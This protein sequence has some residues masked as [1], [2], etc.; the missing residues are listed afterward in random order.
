V[1]T[2]VRILRTATGLL[3]LGLLIYFGRVDL[4]V[5]RE[6]L[7]HPAL[8]VLAG[9]L[10]VSAVPIAALRWWLLLAA[11]EFP[12][13]FPWT[14]RTT[15]TSN[16]F[17]VFLPGSIGGDMVRVLLARRAAQRGISRL[18]STVVVDRL[19]GL[20]ALIL[21]AVCV[22]PA[23]PAW[24]HEP[25]YL[26]ALAAVCAALPAGIAIGVLAGGR[27][28]GVLDRFPAPLGPRLAHGIREVLAALDA[29]AG[30]WPVLVHALLLSVLQF[31]IVLVCLMVLGAA[32]S[33]H[34]LS[35]SGY[36]VAGVWSI[37]ANFLP[38]TPGGLGVGEAAFAQL[39]A[40]LEAVPS[41]ASYGNVFL[42]TR[43]LNVLITVAGV[44]P[45]LAQR[46]EL[47]GTELA[48]ASKL[49]P[50]GAGNGN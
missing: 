44:L 27:I 45:Y 38:I 29:Y 6:A 18:A 15:F 39:A 37:I 30:R 17:N 19:S 31:L 13:S 11:L 4:K 33:F 47:L 22:V 10:L 24:L 8:L 9:T 32:M 28:A 42:A 43:I 46:G 2:I 35:P 40:A 14:L 25:V 49:P 1:T 23:L 12:M 50:P 7:Q 3:V 41:G 5:L 48:A 16:F 21:L 20:A 36:I 26:L 34:G